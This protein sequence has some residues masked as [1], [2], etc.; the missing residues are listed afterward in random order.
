MANMKSVDKR[1]VLM[2]FAAESVGACLGALEVLRGKESY[3]AFLSFT[4]G[5]VGFH[6]SLDRY[7][8]GELELE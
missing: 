5:Y 2:D 7:R 4:G 6:T 1:S 8:L 3:A